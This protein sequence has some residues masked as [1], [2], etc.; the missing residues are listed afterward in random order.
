MT[1]EMMGICTQICTQNGNKC[2]KESACT[3]NEAANVNQ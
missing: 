1:N 3:N 2:I